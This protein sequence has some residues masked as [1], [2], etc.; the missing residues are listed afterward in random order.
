MISAPLYWIA[1]QEWGLNGAA[2][3]STTLTYAAVGAAEPSSSEPARR[4]S[5]G[6]TWCRPCHDVH[7]MAGLEGGADLAALP[8]GRPRAPLA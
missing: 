4:T 1:V 8:V 7:H 3:V 6:A 2:T 5:R